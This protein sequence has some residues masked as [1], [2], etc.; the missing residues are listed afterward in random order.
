MI[1]LVEADLLNPECW[2]KVVSG[3]D[4]ILHVA[5]PFPN[6]MPKNE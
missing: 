6:E 4:Y 3:V 1:E 5:S 2:D